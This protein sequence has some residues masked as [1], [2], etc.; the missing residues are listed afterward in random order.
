M[1]GQEN[2]SASSRRSP[3][4]T[5]DERSMRGKGE[6]PVVSGRYI[7]PRVGERSKFWFV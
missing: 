7:L 3:A 6:D 1:V 2:V 4:V 5:D